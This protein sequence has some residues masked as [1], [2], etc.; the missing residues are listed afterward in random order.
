LLVRALAVAGHSSGQLD[1]IIVVIPREP[2]LLEGHC[3][4]IGF[5]L[6]TNSK[7]MRM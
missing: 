2:A 3:S 5:I 1:V 6:H 7:M 4:N